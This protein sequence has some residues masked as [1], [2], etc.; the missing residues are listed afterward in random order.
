M[1]CKK[2]ILFKLK[3]SYFAFTFT[4]NFIHIPYQNLII[5][6]DIFFFINC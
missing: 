2:L 6:P 4:F 3:I 5:I 1:N